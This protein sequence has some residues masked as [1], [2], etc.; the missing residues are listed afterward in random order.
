MAGC[1]ILGCLGALISRA[2]YVG[3][4]CVDGVLRLRVWRG[5]QHHAPFCVLRFGDWSATYDLGERKELDLVS[6]APRNRT[7]PPR[8]G[9]NY[10]STI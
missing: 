1:F 3:C 8:I 2:T 10:V 4:A 6:E 9:I 7:H 5:S